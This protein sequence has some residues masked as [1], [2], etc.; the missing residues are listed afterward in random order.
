M[1]TNDLNQTIFRYPGYRRWST[2][3]YNISAFV[4]PVYIASLA[5]FRAVTAKLHFTSAGLLSL[6]FEA[7]FIST[8]LVLTANFYPE[9]RVDRNGL[10][11]SFLWYRLPVTWQ[12]IIEIKPSI[13][14]LPK[15]PTTW[16]VR[17]QAL[18]P[19]HRLYGLLYGFTAHPSFIITHGIA[20]CDKLIQMINQHSFGLL[21]NADK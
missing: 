18:T 11:V 6:V 10:Y 9:V 5:I 16:V 14:N 3:L 17:T 7:I 2:I 1:L 12:D 21:D 15:H 8:V 19:F 13:F 20:N 4:I